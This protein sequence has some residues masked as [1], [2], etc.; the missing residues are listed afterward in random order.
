M[1]VRTY[2]P[3]SVDVVVGGATLE[4]FAEGSMV[5]VAYNSDAF[6]LSM[7]TNGQGSRAQ[8]DDLSARVTVHLAQ[9]SPSND[10]LT[11]FFNADRESPTGV[12]LPFMLKDRSGRTI[13]TAETLWIVKPADV[14][15]NNG[16]SERAWT[17]E[18]DTMIAF[19]GGND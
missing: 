7:G 19:I 13:C 1:P 16:I 2:S 5:E 6:V 17:L 12:P 15:F 14:A 11:A 10:V 9:T 18:T 4:G 8:N 3:K